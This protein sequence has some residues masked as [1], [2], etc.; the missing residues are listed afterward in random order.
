MEFENAGFDKSSDIEAMK[1]LLDGNKYRWGVW[2]VF[3]DRDTNSFATMLPN[4]SFGGAQEA[5][6]NVHEWQVEVDW[7]ESLSPDNPRWCKSHCVGGVSVIRIYGYRGKVFCGAYDQP[8]SHAEPVSD[9]LAAMLEAE[10][11]K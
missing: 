4:G 2:T 9:E 6:R 11:G 10:V 1:S 3:F 8:Y 5:L 7:K